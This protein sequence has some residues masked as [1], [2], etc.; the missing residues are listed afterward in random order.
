[1]PRHERKV[2]IVEDNELIRMLLKLLLTHAPVRLAI[3]EAE[4]G[5]EGFHMARQFYPDLII[6]DLDM[7]MMDGIQL[8]RMLRQQFD[9]KLADVP[10]IVATGTSSEWRSKCME[11]GANIVIEKPVY[12]KDLISAVLTLL[13]PD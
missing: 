2:L 11:A 8:C 9:R 6:S 1:M 12:K 10:I 13:E 7:P 5:E 3:T 4:N